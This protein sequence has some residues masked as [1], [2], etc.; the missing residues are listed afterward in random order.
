MALKV[1]V[2][3]VPILWNNDDVPELTPP[4]QFERVILEM[5]QAGFQ[6]SELGTNY[7]RDPERLKAALRGRGLVL[8]GGYFCDDYA[9]RARHDEI[10]AAGRGGCLSRRG[11]RGLSGCRR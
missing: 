4:V 2:G 6:A 9:V 1:K 11:R 7:P 3:T 5:A 8:S 10:V